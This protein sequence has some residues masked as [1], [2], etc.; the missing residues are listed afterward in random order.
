MQQ[1]ETL[2]KTNPEYFI[3]YK[4]RP[5]LNA[6]NKKLLYTAFPE[7]RGTNIFDSFTKKSFQEI[8]SNLLTTK[9]PVLFATYYAYLQ[10][11]TKLSDKKYNEYNNIIGSL[12]DENGVTEK[13]YEIVYSLALKLREEKRIRYL[14][15]LSTKTNLIVTV[16]T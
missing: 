6:Y 11:N 1:V 2:Y 8:N 10:L 5:A 13:E 15:Y 9:Y 3:Y 14:K 16:D 7:T 4:I 12:F